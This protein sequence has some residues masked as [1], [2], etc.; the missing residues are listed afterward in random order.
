M[1]IIANTN[2]NCILKVTHTLP[3]QSKSTTTHRRNSK[4]KR[5]SCDLRE[6]C[7]D[8]TQQKSST[9]IS[10]NINRTLHSLLRLNV[11]G[12]TLMEVS[13]LIVDFV[14]FLINFVVLIFWVFRPKIRFFK[15]SN[16]FFDFFFL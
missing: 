8:G 7:G 14:S 15:I 1:R 4:Q 6:A 13:S 16:F 9:Q 11:C 2:T 3:S 5:S 10:N 12:L